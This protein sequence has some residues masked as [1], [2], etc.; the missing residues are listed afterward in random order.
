MDYI[1]VFFV[2][3]L[4]CNCIPHLSAGLQ[5]RPFPTPFAKPRGVGNSSALVNF[6]W[7]ATNLFLG[8]FLFLRHR[9]FVETA[10]GAGVLTLGF[11]VAGIYLSRHFEKVTQGTHRRSG[12][13]SRLVP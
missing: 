10:L 12:P 13:Q 8:L 11:V 1:R 3:A 6:L 2:G 5:G 9:A 7:G 4:L